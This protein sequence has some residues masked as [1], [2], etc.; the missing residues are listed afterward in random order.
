MWNMLELNGMEMVSAKSRYH[1][2]YRTVKNFCMRNTIVWADNRRWEIK[3]T[4]ERGKHSDAKSIGTMDKLPVLPV[5]FLFTIEETP[6]HSGE[7]EFDQLRSIPN[8]FPSPTVQH[9]LLIQ[10]SWLISFGKT[11]IC[12]YRAYVTAGHDFRHNEH[13]NSQHVIPHDHKDSIYE[14]SRGTATIDLYL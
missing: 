6:V 5:S 13:R 12:E 2:I 11:L 3:R 4:T 7:M 14:T 1:Y 8:V 10:T 9:S